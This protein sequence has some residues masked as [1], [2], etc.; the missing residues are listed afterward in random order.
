VG[1]DVEDVVFACTERNM[2]KELEGAETTTAEQR[3][4]VSVSFL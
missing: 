1:D 2:E 4:L 3:Q